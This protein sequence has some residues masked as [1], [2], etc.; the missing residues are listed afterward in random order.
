MKTASREGRFLESKEMFIVLKEKKMISFL[1]PP[2]QIAIC[3]R[4]RVR[5]L[6]YN[7]V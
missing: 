5:E 4:S 2:I 1:V 6:V 7:L 3:A